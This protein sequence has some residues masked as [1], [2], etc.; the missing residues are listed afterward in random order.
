M[1]N[2]ISCAGKP[3]VFCRSND[4]LYCVKHAS[5]SM[6]TMS[7][8]VLPLAVSTNASISKMLLRYMGMLEWTETRSQHRPSYPMRQSKCI[9]FVRRLL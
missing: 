8:R 4:K 9:P 6:A 5:F 3:Q 1:R 2:L 7:A